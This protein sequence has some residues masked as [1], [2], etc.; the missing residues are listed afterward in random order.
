MFCLL[1]YLVTVTL[2]FAGAVWIYSIVG[3]IIA[4][5]STFQSA[6]AEAFK[7]WLLEQEKQFMDT[8]GWNK[9]LVC[10]IITAIVLILPLCCKLDSYVRLL[11]GGEFL[12]D[13]IGESPFEDLWFLRLLPGMVF[14]AYLAL[15]IVVSLFYSQAEFDIESFSLFG[16]NYNIF[17]WIT[18]ISYFLIILL[19]IFLVFD[20]FLSAGFIGGIFH[21][22]AVLTSNILSFV[23]FFVILITLLS[24]V[25]VA[26][27]MIL[28]VLAVI[29][30]FSAGYRVVYVYY[31]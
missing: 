25:P 17:Q 5:D 15:R 2:S 10:G 26:I 30:V 24:A 7:T 8:D 12:E 27:G 9:I 4:A 16:E 20:S 21:L 14:S 11:P 18:Q 3:N 31:Y 28:T 1:W 29:G 6:E 19:L 23:L 13:R 22:A